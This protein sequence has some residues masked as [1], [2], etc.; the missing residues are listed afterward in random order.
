MSSTRCKS[1]SG[2]AS[3][4][5][6]L[7]IRAGL[8]GFDAFSSPM[9]TAIFDSMAAAPP[10]SVFEV[11][12]LKKELGQEATSDVNSIACLPRPAEAFKSRRT[13]SRS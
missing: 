5:F 7:R 11:V 8:F 4:R 12:D 2:G 9:Q 6:L 10:G 13:A 3:L 1:L